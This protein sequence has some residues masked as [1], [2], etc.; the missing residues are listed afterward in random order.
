MHISFRC[1]L[2]MHLGVST[3]VSENPSYHNVYRATLLTHVISPIGWI[4]PAEV[5]PLYLR[6][7]VVSIAT[8][9]NWLCNFSLTFFTPPAFQNIQWRFYLIFGTFCAAAFL[10][11]YFFFQET[12]GKTLEEIDD[13]FD[14]NTFAFGK[15]K[16]TEENLAARIRHAEKQLEEGEKIDLIK[17]EITGP[18]GNQK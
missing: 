2:C 1:Y 5:I 16:G 4:Y 18:L 8:L 9:F 17:G 3:R 14:N 11:V 7:K 12:S 10:H 13:I 6:S 15:V